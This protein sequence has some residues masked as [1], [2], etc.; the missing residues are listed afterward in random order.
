MIL[1][2]EFLPSVD[3]LLY[4]D[5]SN[6]FRLS[7]G[8]YHALNQFKGTPKHEQNAD[9]SVNGGYTKAL[10]KDVTKPWLKSKIESGL[11][12]VQDKAK[13]VVDGLINEALSKIPGYSLAKN[14]FGGSSKTDYD[15]LD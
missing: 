3:E 14:V 8:E 10:A 4:V 11:G 2:E 12:Y 9:P 7:V 1:V 5:S 13:T 6:G 15:E